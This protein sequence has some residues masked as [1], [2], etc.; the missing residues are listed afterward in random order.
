LIKIK[1]NNYKI[2]KLSHVLNFEIFLKNMK[3]QIN[4]ILVRASFK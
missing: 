3:I 2:E 1:L 4:V